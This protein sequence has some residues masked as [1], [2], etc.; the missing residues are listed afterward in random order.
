MASWG[1]NHAAIALYVREIA[2][3]ESEE[4]RLRIA[5]ASAEARLLLRPHSALDSA[6]AQ[7]VAIWCSEAAKSVSHLT[8]RQLEIMDMVLAGCPSK[9]IASDLGISRR[10]VENHR[11]AIMRRTGSKSLPEL[12]KIGFAAH[13]ATHLSA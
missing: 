3:H 12:G 13:V 4:T 8:R 2:L 6:P 9:N 11:A 7:G 10:T 5:L 1:G